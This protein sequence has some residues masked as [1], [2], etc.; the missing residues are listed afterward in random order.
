M[1][2]LRAALQGLPIVVAPWGTAPVELGKW[3]VELGHNGP[4]VL[5]IRLDGQH[6][7]AA[8]E[9]VDFWRQLNYQ[10]ERLAT[11]SLRTCLLINEQNDGRMAIIA[12]DLQEWISFF[13]FPEVEVVRAKWEPMPLRREPEEVPSTAQIALLRSQWQRALAAG[14]SEAEVVNSY[15]GPLFKALVNSR[16]YEEANTVWER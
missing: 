2:R 8:E 10:R 4:K 12:V 9:A 3:A 14:L 16:Q 1:Q 6:A 5:I 15:T 13:R 11:G 7:V